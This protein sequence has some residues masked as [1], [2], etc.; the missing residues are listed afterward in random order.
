[1]M[2]IDWLR[3]FPT[4]QALSFLAMLLIFVMAVVSIV[5]WDS[6]PEGLAL[7]LGGLAGVSVAQFAV[8]RRTDREYV[9]LKGEAAASVARASGAQP[10]VVATGPAVISTQPA[11]TPAAPSSEPDLY[12]DDERGE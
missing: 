1:M 3:D 10:Q 11:G 8:K 5:K 4:T 7:F 9:Q 2:K 6:P 12:H